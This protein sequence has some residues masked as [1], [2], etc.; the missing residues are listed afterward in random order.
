MLR[1]PDQPAVHD[2]LTRSGMPH[3]APR[4]TPDPSLAKAPIPVERRLPVAAVVWTIAILL[5][6]I[7]AFASRFYMNADGISYLNLSDI[8]ARGDWGS[9]VNG[10]WSPLYPFLLSIPRKLFRPSGYWEA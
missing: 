4:E 3:P 5:G 1:E 8:I 10:Y 9:A 7:Q 6:C 2:T